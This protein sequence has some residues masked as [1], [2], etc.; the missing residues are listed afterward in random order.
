MTKQELNTACDFLNDRLYPT[1][2]V[3]Y[4]DFVDVIDRW[5]L[6]DEFRKVMEAVIK[7]SLTTE[8]TWHK[9]SEELPEE[10]KEVIVIYDNG[11]LCYNHRPKMG[12]YLCR[13]D[14]EKV[15]YEP[16]VDEDG[17]CDYSK[18]ST[19]G[20]KVILWTENPIED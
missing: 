7:E 6:I 13:P 8:L 16:L 4:E 19:K 20:R 3:L 12:G 5:E 15:P 1:V 18:G 17:W 2:K 14:G 9:A 11:Y 10:E